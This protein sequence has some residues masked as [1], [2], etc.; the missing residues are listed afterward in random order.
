MAQADIVLNTK[1]VIGGELKQCLN[2]WRMSQLY[3]RT[4]IEILMSTDL[5]MGQMLEHCSEQVE[6]EFC[7]ELDITNRV[8]ID[9]VWDSNMLRLS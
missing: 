3:W 9:L 5:A 1:L 8:V 6:I 7:E 2:N 4:Q